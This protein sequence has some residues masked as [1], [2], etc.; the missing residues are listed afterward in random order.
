[1]TDELTLNKTPP[2][3]SSLESTFLKLGFTKEQIISMNITAGAYVVTNPS[4][5]LPRII[6][7]IDEQNYFKIEYSHILDTTL[8]KLSFVLDEL[9]THNL[10]F[11]EGELVDEQ[12]GSILDDFE[13]IPSSLSEY[14]TYFKSTIKK[15][16]KLAIINFLE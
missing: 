9:A 12:S 1:M 8:D 7:S 10:S 4:N 14:G 16:K 11:Q 3:F 6:S 2:L 13:T 5:D 15:H